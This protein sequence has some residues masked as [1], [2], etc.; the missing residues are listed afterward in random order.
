M[1]INEH[2]TEFAGLPVVAFDPQVAP[3]VAADA[4]AWRLSAEYDTAP[5]D[6]A[7]HLYTANVHDPDLLIRTSGEQRLS[8]FLLWQAAYA[9]LYFTD[10]LW[11]DFDEEAMRSA[12]AEY[13]RRERRYGGL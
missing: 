10:T 1:T 6:F 5:E 9:E 7:D 2:L 3:P 13:A 4:A 8:N 11:P 12:L